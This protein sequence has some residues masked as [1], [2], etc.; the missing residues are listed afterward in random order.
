MLQFLAL[1]ALGLLLSA[2]SGGGD[3]SGPVAPPVELVAVS[4]LAV[5]AGSDSSLTLAWTSPSAAAKA[6]LGIR[7]ELHY[8]T[9]AGA[10]A[11]WSQWTPATPPTPDAASGTYHTH[12]VRGLQPGTS[13][14]FALRASTGGD[15]WSAI[16]NLTLATAAADYDVTRPA[17]IR[18]LQQWAGTAGSLTF[19]WTMAGDDSVYGLAAAHEVRYAT[20]PITAGNWEQALAG[21]VPT[22]SAEASGLMQVT[23]TGLA[24]ETP[25]YCAVVAVDDRGLRS[26]LSNV[27]QATTGDLRVIRV[28]VDRTGDYPTIE[29]AIFAARPGDL[30]L[31]GPGRYTW[32]NQGTGDDLHGMILV[33]RDYTDIV[34]RSLAGPERTILDAEEQ[35][36]IMTVTG[37]Y[38]VQPDGSRN[39]AGITVDGFTFTGGRTT[40]NAAGGF[41]AHL[42]DSVVRNCIFHDNHGVEGGA[43]WFGG[44][45]DAVLEDCLIYDNWASWGGGV[46]L[47]NSE[48]RLTVRRC[49]IRNN[50][51]TTT[52][53]GIFAVHCTMTVEDCLIYGNTSGDRGGGMSCQQMNPGAEV[54]RCTIADN[55]AQ[56]RGS[57]LYLTVDTVVRLENTVVAYN[58]VA[59]VVSLVSNSTL[60]MGCSL[61]YGNPGSNVLPAGVVDLG[62]NLTLDPLY[63][64]LGRFRPGPDSP[65]LPANHPG[66]TGCGL[67]GAVGQGCGGKS[68]LRS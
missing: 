43:V 16:S 39:Y 52:G 10:A 38:V 63:C 51:A 66:G 37:G 17:A 54:L 47:I 14:V 34:V 18:D 60:Q 29:D 9:V 68:R 67:I 20:E 31:V 26:G 53:G 32:S 24:A 23:L 59:P 46:M 19:G 6:G 5:V 33:D 62:G 25:Y 35:G 30:V 7:Y 13:H 58:R 1:A 65:C 61:V 49:T 4:D 55:K 40:A 8:T 42:S 36:S 41:N 44:Q 28:N 50:W 12:E 21:P 27:A 57:G 3:E 64:D 15:K 2:C 45:G 56:V 11:D 48:P 22:P